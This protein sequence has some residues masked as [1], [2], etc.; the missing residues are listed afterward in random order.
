MRLRQLVERRDDD[1]RFLQGLPALVCD[2]GGPVAQPPAERC[3][4]GQ[5]A[6]R[7]IGVALAHVAEIAP[8]VVV[9]H[10]AHV[11][12]QAECP[13]VG[14]RNRLRVGQLVAPALHVAQ[15]VARHVVGIDLAAIA[16]LQ[17][18]ELAVQVDA[19]LADDGGRERGVAVGGDV[20]V[21]GLCIFQPAGAAVGHSGREQA[22]AALFRQRKTHASWQRHDGHAIEHQ[23]PVLDIALV[24]L[25]VD[26]QTLAAHIPGRIRLPWFARIGAAG[27]VDTVVRHAMLVVEEL[28]PAG[29]AGAAGLENGIADVVEAALEG[30][31][32][33]L[34]PVATVDI[35]FAVDVDLAGGSDGIGGLVVVERL[36]LD[37]TAGLAQF[38]IA[39]GG[40]LVI[41]LAVD[42][43]GMDDGGVLA[44]GGW[45]YL[46][47]QPGAGLQGEGGALRAGQ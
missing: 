30:V 23:C 22:G 7:Q 33:Q 5:Y 27:G 18:A 45:R 4:A 9:A 29:R 25:G 20:H 46:F 47:V 36:A 3:R 6:L 10:A 40:Q 15:L 34:Q 43:V 39:G 42:A 2:I 32:L 16:V 35:A 44:G 19:A 12:V 13:P 14:G 31:H 26:H 1:V 11:Q 28:D 8:V 38:G 21:I 24:L 41:H 17:I 37:H